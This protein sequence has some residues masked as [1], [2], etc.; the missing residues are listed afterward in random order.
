VITPAKLYHAVGHDPAVHH[1]VPFGDQNEYL[2]SGRSAEMNERRKLG[3]WRWARECRIVGHRTCRAIKVNA[4][5]LYR[6]RG[7]VLEDPIII[8]GAAGQGRPSVQCPVSRQLAAV[9]HWTSVLIM[10]FARAD[11]GDGEVQAPYPSHRREQPVSEQAIERKG[12]EPCSQQRANDQTAHRAP[13]GRDVMRPRVARYSAA[14]LRARA[15]D[16]LAVVA[17]RGLGRGISRSVEDAETS[18][19]RIC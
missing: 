5:P 11:I 17:D 3:S 8:V 13:M 16:Y 10:Q 15:G 6:L 19:G 2:Q 18:S 14:L 4:T 7:V 1:F 9:H 12:E